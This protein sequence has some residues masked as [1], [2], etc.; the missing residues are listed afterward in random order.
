[1]EP[2]REPE[3]EEEE[4]EGKG[5]GEDAPSDAQRPHWDKGGTTG[6]IHPRGPLAAP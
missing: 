4:E 6:P 3:G 5:K 2:A 1:M